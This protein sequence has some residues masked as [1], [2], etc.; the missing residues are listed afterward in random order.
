M[1]WARGKGDRRIKETGSI[2]IDPV[3]RSL[4]LEALFVGNTSVHNCSVFV[5]A[6]LLWSESTFASRVRLRTQRKAGKRYGASQ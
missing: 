3:G 1:D 4:C 6:D 5:N 2:M